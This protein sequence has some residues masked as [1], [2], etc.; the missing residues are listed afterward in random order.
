MTA[1]TLRYAVATAL[2]A[3]LA[4]AGCKKDKPVDTAATPPPMSTP[5]PSQPATPPPMSSAVSITS[6]TLGKAAGADKRIESAT[7]DFASTDPI[8]VSVATNGSSGS[9]TIHTRLMYQDGQVAGEE[10]QSIATD[11]METTNFTFNNANGWPAGNY[12]AEVSVDNA[13]PRTTTFTVK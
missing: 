7:T 2:M 6:V 1:P 11:G 13:A 9:T 3:S 4:L 12:T 8:V 5:A 10:S